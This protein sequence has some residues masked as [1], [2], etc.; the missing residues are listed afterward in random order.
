MSDNIIKFPACFRQPDGSY[1]YAGRRYRDIEALD[2]V[3][4]QKDYDRIVPLGLRQVR[5]GACGE[6][7]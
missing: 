2:E 1:V 7:E 4:T 3:V 6:E 5:E